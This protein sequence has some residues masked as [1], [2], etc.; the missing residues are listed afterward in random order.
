MHRQDFRIDSNTVWALVIG[1]LALIFLGAVGK[2]QH[3]EYA[4]YFISAGLALFF[5]SWM[6]VLGDMIRNQVYNK[7]F[8]IASMFI[9]PGIS[10]I[11]YLIQ[12]KRLLRLGQK[13]A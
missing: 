10:V 9:I 4:R 8:W 12:R 7:V 5:F 11:F 6:I 13:F 3:W 2:L 1:Y